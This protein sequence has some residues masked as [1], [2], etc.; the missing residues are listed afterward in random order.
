[1]ICPSIFL[2]LSKMEVS[3]KLLWIEVFKV[4]NEGEEVNVSKLAL[5]SKI[6]R[7]SIY[8]IIQNKSFNLQN[9]VVSF[10]IKNGYVNSNLINKTP[11][12]TQ[13]K[14]YKKAPLKKILLA[15]TIFNQEQLISDIIIYLNLSADKD[16]KINTPSYRTLILARL[17]EGYKIEQFKK[18][19]DIKSAEWK[20]NYMEK[21]LRPITLF[22]SKMDGYVNENPIL[23]KKGINKIK[24]TVDEAS[25]FNF[26]N[27]KPL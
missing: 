15:G 10:N 7:P 21:Y 2:K 4:F 27:Q 19:I 8:R 16:Y 25:A 23:Q 17:K 9:G 3:E 6:T 1:M 26:E 13:K 20:D 24:N 5:L 14:I 11:I 18:V 22:S 12:K